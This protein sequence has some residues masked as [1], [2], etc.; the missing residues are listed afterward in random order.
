M[1]NFSGKGSYKSEIYG[2]NY[3]EYSRNRR[4]PVHCITIVVILLWRVFTRANRVSFTIPVT[5]V[6]RYYPGAG[7]RFWLII[8]WWEFL[9]PRKETINYNNY[10]KYTCKLIAQLTLFVSPD[11]SNCIYSCLYNSRQ[12]LNVD[13]VKVL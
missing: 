12:Y 7:L 9:D 10:I 3:F 5:S 11:T 2:F 13:F 8:Y 1:K 6:R 4:S